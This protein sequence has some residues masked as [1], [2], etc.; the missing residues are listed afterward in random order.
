MPLVLSLFPGIGLLDMAF[1][2]EGFCVVRGPDVL[3]GGDVR[4]F[5]PPAGKFDGVIG[6]PPCQ[7]F[8]PLAHMVRHNGHEPK[9]GNLIPEFERCVHEARP[10][11]FVMENVPAAPAPSVSGYEIHSFILNNRQCIGEDGKPAEQNR[12]RRWSFGHLGERRPLMVDV[13]LW[14][15]PVIEYAAC[16]GTHGIGGIGRE[17]IARAHRKKTGRNVTLKDCVGFN[18]KSKESVKQLA[19][20]QGLPIEF[21]IEPF[22]VQAKCK[23]I[24]NGVPI[25]MG[26]SIAR[27]VKEAIGP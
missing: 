1:E 13:T 20:L 27:A 11:W 6:G 2:Q 17:E 4:R 18:V 8:S 24:G 16:G 15:N 12:T 19:K 3:W 5:H 14:E 21:D 26:R 22:T 7:A 9:F 10:Q 25:P 23:A